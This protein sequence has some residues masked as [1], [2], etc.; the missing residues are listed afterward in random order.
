MGRSPTEARLPLFPPFACP[1]GTL[2]GSRGNPLS[3]VDRRGGTPLPPGE[4]RRAGVPRGEAPWWGGGAKPLLGVWGQS[5]Q[6][7]REDGR[8]GGR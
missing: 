8:E 4:A 6:V 1:K 5:P 7:G 3:G 2:K